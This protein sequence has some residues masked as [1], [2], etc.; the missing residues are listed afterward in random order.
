MAQIT[1][2]SIQDWL[3]SLAQDKYPEDH[4]YIGSPDAE[5]RGVLMCWFAD[6]GAREAALK[7]GANLIIA[8]ETLGFTTPQS[9]PGCPPSADW[10][11]NRRIREFYEK[12]G[13]AYIQCHRT[14]DAFCI[15][16]RL[17]EFLGFPDPVIHQGH[18]GYE[19]TLVYDLAPVPFGALARQ[20]KARMK[21]PA[22]R[23][24]ACDP[25]K[26]VRRVGSGWG[27]VSNSR[28]LQYMELLLRHGVKVV[29]GGEV[30]E[31]ALEYYRESGMEW[32]E[33]GH[34]AT[35]IIGIEYAAQQMAKA[36]P[37]LPVRCYRDTERMR[38]VCTATERGGTADK[39]G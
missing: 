32:I 4:I 19:F 13:I 5:G 20:L 3:A 27:G 37:G 11:C 28:N 8:H 18:K 36:F 35:E 6:P 30:D 21:L 24:S 34:Y 25:N 29:I 39:R 12:N 31:Y 26:I 16:R 2:Q 38:V 17:G 1:I 9:D 22:V 33:L 14:L 15:P 23:A 7:N 10:R